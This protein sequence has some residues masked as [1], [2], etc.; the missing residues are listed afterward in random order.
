MTVSELWHYFVRFKWSALVSEQMEMYEVIHDILH[1]SVNDY[2]HYRQVKIGEVNVV[3]MKR[4]REEEKWR[5]A[6]VNNSS[7][8]SL[9]S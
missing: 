2:M 8:F 7:F 4:L 1:A 3:L 9:F 6:F 5:E